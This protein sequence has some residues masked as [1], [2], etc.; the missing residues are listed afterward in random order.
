MN[1]SHSRSNSIEEDTERV[2]KR[3][4]LESPKQQQQEEESFLPVQS[5][6]TLPPDN[7]NEESDSIPIDDVEFD[8]FSPRKTKAALPSWEG[9]KGRPKY[10]LKYSLTGHKKSISSVKF[11]PDG[12]WLASSCKGLSL[13]HSL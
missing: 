13:T 7:T 12:K 5:T 11:S 4:R 1:Q 6:S 3:A 8:N 10:K 9:N 2:T